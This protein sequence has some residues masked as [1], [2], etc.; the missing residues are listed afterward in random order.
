MEWIK[1]YKEFFLLILVA[2]T[3][4]PPSLRIR[5][6]EKVNTF[7]ARTFMLISKDKDELL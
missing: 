1:L 7:D 2:Q 4:D 5:P 6:H 3:S